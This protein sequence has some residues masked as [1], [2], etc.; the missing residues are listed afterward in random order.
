[1]NLPCEIAVWYLI[2]VVKSELAKEL[3]NRGLTQKEAAE[4]LGVT[5]A[6][7]SNYMSEKRGVGDKS[8]KSI[9]EEIL[10]L[11]EEMVKPDSSETK[12]A[13]TIC[14]I[15]MKSKSNGLLCTLHR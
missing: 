8:I 11:A 1:M 14:L 4:K 2:P 13:Q 10:E 12:V 15:C 9:K 5:Q 6:A 3:V 7:V